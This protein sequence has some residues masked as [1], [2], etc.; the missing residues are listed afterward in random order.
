MPSPWQA[1]IAFLSQLL[2]C[3]VTGNLKFHM[4]GY[5]VNRPLA[6]FAEDKFDIIPP[7]Q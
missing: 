3:R 5:G 6:Q 1:F 7:W 4:E 2:I